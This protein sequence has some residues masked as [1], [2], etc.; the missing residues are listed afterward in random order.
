ML[1]SDPIETARLIL[2]PER[3]EDADAIH[4]MNCDPQVMRYIGDGR[5]WTTPLSAFRDQFRQTLARNAGRPWGGVAVVMKATGQFIGL[6]WLAPSKL[7]DGRIE[8]GC[9]YVTEAWGKGL[10]TEAAQCVLRVGFDVLHLK[11]VEATVRSDNL[12]SIRVLEKLGFRRREECF[13]DRAGRNV[14]IYEMASP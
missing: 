7:L 10:A 9:R 4:A 14:Y 11:S 1:M 12:G 2:R 3:L 8:L 5:P 13:D 6:C